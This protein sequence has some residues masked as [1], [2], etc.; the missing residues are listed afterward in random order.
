MR[1]LIAALTLFVIGSTL[2]ANTLPVKAQSEA[3]DAA[4]VDKKVIPLDLPTS[5]GDS[6]GMIAADVNGDGARD[7]VISQ[8]GDPDQLGVYAS[9]GDKLWKRTPDLWLGDKTENEGLPGLHGPGVQAG[10][11]DGDGDAEV[12]FVNAEGALLLLDGA[13]GATEHAVSLPAVDSYYGRWEHVVLAD[14][15][16]DAGSDVLLQASGDVTGND[17]LKG[18]HIAAYSTDDLIENGPTAE[19]LFARDDFHRPGHRVAGVADLD[20]DGR[21]EVIGAD[22]IDDTG[23]TLVSLS[24]D[25][26][27]REHIDSYQYGDIDSDRPGLEVAAAKQGGGNEV[28]LYDPEGI[29]WKYSKKAAATDGDKVQIGDFAPD[30]RGLELYLR[31]KNSNDQ[32]VLS[33]R[34]EKI[35]DYDFDAESPV[36]WHED[37]VESIWDVQWSGDPTERLAAKERHTRG[38]IGVYDALDPSSDFQTFDDATDRLYVADVTGDW[39]EEL[40]VLS[41]DELHVYQNESPNP[42]PDRSRLW[43]DR[44][45]RLDRMTWNY[46]SP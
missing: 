26:T 14:F 31:G 23:E 43:S 24:L 9:S 22:L 17:Y 46:Y 8:Q 29:I 30:R 25:R 4:D 28:V 16:D 10:D 34:G 27:S 5:W 12:M 32:W 19:A 42:S 37:G 11:A 40:M 13:T 18:V 44:T 7:F 21:D 41:G 45:Y 20:A 15:D 36:G 33:S 2:P 35:A 38:D 3:S 6:G 39:R 1:S